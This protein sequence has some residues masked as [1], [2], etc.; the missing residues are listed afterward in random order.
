MGTGYDASSEYS[1]DTSPISSSGRSSPMGTMY[2]ADS[3]GS[4]SPPMRGAKRVKRPKKEQSDKVEELEKRNYD[5]DKLL[6][7]VSLHM[8]TH[9]FCN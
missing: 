9:M 5:G 4:G 7:E 8:C 6:Q 3:E 2:D 1:P